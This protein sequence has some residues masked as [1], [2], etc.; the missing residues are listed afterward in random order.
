[1]G[2]RTAFLGLVWIRLFGLEP[3]PFL[4]S[5]DGGS[6]MDEGQAHGYVCMIADTPCF[7]DSVWNFKRRRMRGVIEVVVRMDG[8]EKK[9]WTFE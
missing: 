5:S 1:M 7:V 4:G 9:L 6:G 2:L 8:R 3:V